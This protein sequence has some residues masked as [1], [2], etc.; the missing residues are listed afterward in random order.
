M[1]RFH[2]VAATPSL[3][4]ACEAMSEKRFDKMVRCVI[5]IHTNII[6]LDVIHS[7]LDSSN[8]EGLTCSQ[9]CLLYGQP[10]RIQ[11]LSEFSPRYAVIFCFLAETCGN[12]ITYLKTDKTRRGCLHHR[13]VPALGHAAFPRPI[14]KAL[15]Q[16]SVVCAV[17]A[18]AEKRPLLLL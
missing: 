16:Q 11:N 5:H 6:I 17:C 1:E 2:V 13:S 12:R 10:I 3:G 9:I 14:L 15:P 4:V 7:L 18:W 8:V